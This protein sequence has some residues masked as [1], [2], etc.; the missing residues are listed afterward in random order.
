MTT[1][2]PPADVDELK[3]AAAGRWPEIVPALTIIPAEVLD[4]RHHPCPKCAGT[5]RFRAL[6]DFS[7]TGAVLCNQCFSQ[8]NGDGIAAIQHF[9]GVDFK[10]AIHKLADYLGVPAN[11]S[12]K[13]H[14]ANGRAK[15][16]PKKAADVAALTKGIKAVD[17]APEII[18]V[19]FAK[20]SQVKPPITPQGIRQCGGKL[21]RWYGNRCIQLDGRAAIDEPTTT[22]VV[23]L[24]VDGKPF[25]AVGKI[26]ERKTHTVRG[27]VN[28]WIASGD[29]TTAETVL[30]AEGVTDLLAV[31]SAGLPPGW[32]AVTNTA[33]AKARGKLPRPW[34]NGKTVIVAGDA[35]DPGVEGQRRSA[36]AYHEAGAQTLLGQLPYA[37]EKDQGRDIR[38]WLN[39]AHA[40][41]ELPTVEVTAEQAAEW[42]KTNAADGQADEDP[43]T[44]KLL[45]DAIGHD[46]H[47]AQDAGGRLY[48]YVK[49]VFRPSGENFVKS[50]VKQLCVEWGQTKKWSSRLASEVVEFLRVDSPELPDRPPIDLINTESGMVRTQDGELLPHDPKFLSVVQ[51][52]VKFDPA[53]TCPNIESFVRTS[54]PADAHDLAWEIV[55]VLMVPITWLQ[56][57]ILLQGAGGNGKSTWLSLIVRFLGKHNVATIPLHRLE[58]DKF[59]VSRLVGKLANIC[60][61]LPSEHLAGTSTF[62]ALTGG[63]TLPAEFK[64][65]DS[66]DLDPFARLVFSANHP[67]RSA[68]SSAAFFRRW[69]VIPF[70]RSF[71]DTADEIPRDILDSKLQSPKELSGLL[72]R[73]LEGLRRVQRQRRFTEPE[74]VKAAWR[75]FHATTDPLAV[76]LDRYTIDDPDAVVI[77]HVLRVAYNAAVERDGRPAMTAKAFGQAIYKLRPNIDEKQ[78]TIGQKLQWCYVGIGMVSNSADSHDSRDS[79]DSPLIPTTQRTRE[80]DGDTGI[81]EGD[82][83]A[84]YPNRDNP[85]NP[86][87][88]VNPADCLHDWVDTQGEDGETRRKC[89]ICGHFY[90][91]VRRK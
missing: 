12:G 18:E 59:S 55:G 2:K 78:R 56:K 58:V 42:M 19:F 15:R 36:A 3:R 28:S 77:K 62:K 76:W 24:R 41:A 44:I 21:V 69:T 1:T 48:H 71:D 82:I 40:V 7:Q 33:G 61:D 38:D 20:Y 51:L 50:Q 52:P 64:F 90:G 31:A 26:G 10:A 34:A 22:A 75:D 88:E 39:E 11:G 30:D 45:A 89:R 63:D 80:D 32:V 53:A 16:Q 87:N 27:S 68:D 84:E 49:G 57:A 13:A 85:V 66:F 81:K 79:R 29:M 6:D 60:A 73:A 74:S 54:F 25:P 46:H 67:P 17:H 4:G 70:D 72:N 35:D 23:L 5:D 86:V 47:F 91:Y 83:S 9:A 14:A 65:K 37:I 8:D 43:G